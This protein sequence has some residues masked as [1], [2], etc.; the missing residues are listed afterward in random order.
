MAV[1]VV[2]EAVGT[3][4]MAACLT[5]PMLA[6]APACCC[7]PQWRCVRLLC[8]CVLLCTCLLLW[9]CVEMCEAAT[10]LRAIMLIM[11]PSRDSCQCLEGG[12]VCQIRGC[13]SQDGVAV[14]RLCSVWLCVF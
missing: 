10:H 7:A 6:L 4:A 9:T 14:E 13:T 2:I 8:T 11:H 1:V 3:M 5:T 12:R